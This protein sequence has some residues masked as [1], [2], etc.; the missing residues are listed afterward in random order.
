[1]CL[2]GNLLGFYFGI[3]SEPWRWK[4]WCQASGLQGEKCSLWN[5]FCFEDFC[6]PKGLSPAIDSLRTLKL[7]LPSKVK[8]T[9]FSNELWLSSLCHC[10]SGILVLW[11]HRF[12]SGLSFLTQ[13]VRVVSIPRFLSIG[14]GC[15]LEVFILSVHKDDISPLRRRTNFVWGFGGREQGDLFVSTSISKRKRNLFSFQGTLENGRKNY[16][17]Q[18]SSGLPPEN[19]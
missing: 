10:P 12:L 7:P 5:H 14:W 19:P 3:N 18:I 17:F 16:P 1:M 11:Q 15:I 8:L 6:E 13:S 4:Q 2:P 9:C